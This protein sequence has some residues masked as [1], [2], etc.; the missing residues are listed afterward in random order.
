[1][2]I[3]L[4]SGSA[5]GVLDPT[6]NYYEFIPE[7]EADSPSPTVL[8]A[9][10]LVEGQNYFIL[11]TTP[12]GFCRYNIF[13]LVRVVGRFNDTPVLEFLNKGAHIANITGEKLAESQVTRA[14]DATLGEL[15]LALTAFTLAPVWDDVL[16]Y[17]TLLVERTDV[18]TAVQARRLAAGV[19]AGLC[20][21]NSEYQSKRETKRLG[22]VQ[23]GWLPLGAWREFCHKQLAERGGSLEQYKHPC[24]VSDFEFITRMPVDTLRITEGVTEPP[25]ASRVNG[26]GTTNGTARS[27]AS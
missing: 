27:M 20:R 23:L 3:P 21:L 17:Y 26:R 24:L 7:S 22:P 1:M 9:H 14:V 8:E 10:E 4:A 6:V 12:S 11:L 5:G 18:P 16:P 13:D 15:S 25:A 2:T 19:D